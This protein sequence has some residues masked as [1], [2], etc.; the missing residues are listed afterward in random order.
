MDNDGP[1]VIVCLSMCI[2]AVFATWVVTMSI[3][4]SRNFEERI[5]RHGCV[6]QKVGSRDVCTEPDGK[7]Y[8]RH[9]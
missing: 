5:A 9:P 1:W 2:S 7:V 6:V 4:E 3:V 8:L